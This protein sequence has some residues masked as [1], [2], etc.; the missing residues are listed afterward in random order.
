MSSGQ[1][2]GLLNFPRT[3]MNSFLQLLRLRQLVVD[4]EA[5]PLGGGQGD[6]TGGLGGHQVLVEF[7]Q[8]GAGIALPC[9]LDD[10][11]GLGH[12]TLHHGQ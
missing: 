1:I 7:Q 10:G 9:P 4:D 11:M 6:G 5:E 8:Q 12:G 3:P 2:E